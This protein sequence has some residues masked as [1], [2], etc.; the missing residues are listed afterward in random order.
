MK[1]RLILLSVLFFLGLIPGNVSAAEMRR[2]LSPQ[3]PM[4]IFHVDVWNNAD[5]QKIIDLIP[6]D[7]RPYTVFNISLSVTESVTKDGFRTAESWLR[8]CAEN[9]V[10]ALIQPASGGHAWFS[11]YDTSVHRYFFENYPNFLGFNY[12]EQFWGFDDYSGLHPFGSKSPSIADRMNLFVDLLDLADEFGGYLVVSNCLVIPEWD[13]TSPLT[14]FKRYPAFAEAAKM[15]KEHLI[16]CE[17]YTTSGNF[18][19]MES[20]CLGVFLSDHCDNWG[21]RFDQCGYTEHVYNNMP[22]EQKMP[23]A[24]AGMTILEH[25]MMTGQTVQDGPELITNQCVRALSDVRTDDGYNSRRFEL[26]PQFPNV[27][28]DVWRKFTTDG[29]IRIMNRQEVIDSTKI[30]IYNDINPN[31]AQ[32][33]WEGRRSDKNLFTGLYALDKGTFGTDTVY[34]KKTGRYTTVPTIFI[35]NGKDL[36]FQRVIKQSR[37]NS[38]W[39]DT[40]KKVS[41][42]NLLFSP[43]TDDDPET[44]LYVRRIDNNWLVYNNSQYEKQ[45]K[46]ETS[47]IALRY[48]SCDAVTVTMPMYSFGLLTEK[49]DG[50]DIYLNNYTHFKGLTNDTI[51]IKG[52]SEQPTYEVKVRGDYEASK[53]D[54]PSVTSSYADGALT[55]IVAHN[56]PL[57]INVKCRGANSGRLQVPEWERTYGCEIPPVYK[58]TRQYEWENAD[59]SNIDKAWNGAVQ[60]DIPG[61]TA[62]GYVSY[63]TKNGAKLRDHIRIDEAGRYKMTIRYLAP[64]NDV[65]RVNITVN[66][67][68]LARNV[69]FAKTD[70]SNTWAE[71]SVE[72]DLQEGISELVL[73][74]TKTQTSR[75]YLDNFTLTSLSG[76]GVD[77]FSADDAE[78]ASSAVC[79]DIYGRRVNP[80]TLSAGQ[81]YILNGK[82]YVKKN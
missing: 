72:F 11:D 77:S 64:E 31:K 40:D 9:R 57:D 32:N 24:I 20:M 82:K 10:W 55:L 6:D 14:M 38:V 37:I 45:R 17:K 34:L 7:M 33:N 8:T 39:H 67:K 44:S 63:G 53:H 56:G 70:E 79:V 60:T 41:D 28:M 35:E 61:F 26:F 65:D 58:G 25:M 42:F 1:F 13:G 74:S 80:E 47:T 76:S 66:G 69:K 21:M 75:L 2:P 5:P 68:V 59:Y 43:Q 18:Y 49:A 52:C 15:H 22:G 36:G 78:K 3:Q 12:C 4:Y 73:S 50:I 23:P 48:N 51:I 30:A 62:L 81:I 46:V 27:Y 54:L 29:V 19:D 16:Y 71:A